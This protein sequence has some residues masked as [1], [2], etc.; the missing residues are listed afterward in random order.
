MRSSPQELASRFSDMF[1]QRWRTL[2]DAFT[3]HSAL[4][5]T[6]GQ[7]CALASFFV[8]NAESLSDADRRRFAVLSSTSS[9]SA[10]SSNSNPSSPV[11]STSSDV[12]MTSSST[13]KSNTPII[14]RPVN[15]NSNASRPI[16]GGTA[17][18]PPPPPPPAVPPAPQQTKFSLFR[19]EPRLLRVTKGTLSPS[20]KFAPSVG[21]WGEYGEIRIALTQKAADVVS[22]LVE[23][24]E[25]VLR[26]LDRT[27]DTIL[28]AVTAKIHRLVHQRDWNNVMNRAVDLITRRISDFTDVHHYVRPVTG[29]VVKLVTMLR[30]EK[31]PLHQGGGHVLHIRLMPLS[32]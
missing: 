6:H 5:L 25:T 29:D 14:G 22:A 21:G 17:P 23:V 12:S 2:V 10:S 4:S 11:S 15:S 16:I 27:E 18:P 1:L 24:N 31:R 19:L 3:K 13:P 32:A 20:Q 8:A 30:A 28:S 9:G 7:L 26:L